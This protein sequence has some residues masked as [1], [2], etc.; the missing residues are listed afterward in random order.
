MGVP[1]TKDN[2]DRYQLTREEN[3]ARENAQRLIHELDHVL[4]PKVARTV[5]P[6][7]K[8]LVLKVFS[9]SELADLSYQAR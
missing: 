4:T 9:A 8:R 1:Q 6:Q 7:L 2:A 3:R 5:E